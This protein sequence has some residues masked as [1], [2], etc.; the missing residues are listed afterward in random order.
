ILCRSQIVF[1]MQFADLFSLVLGNQGIS[2]C[3]ALV[4]T[5][6]FGK[7]N[8]YDKIEYGSS[9]QHHDA[10]VCFISALAKNLFSRLHS[11]KRKTTRRKPH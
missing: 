10:E 8:Q 11:E 7:T 3:I 1:G 5:I 9:V 2:E 4:V 6:T